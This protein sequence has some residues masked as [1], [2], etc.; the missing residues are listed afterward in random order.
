MTQ[1]QGTVNQDE[2]NDAPS[3]SSSGRSH[4]LAI[5]NVNDKLTKEYTANPN[6]GDTVK[7]NKVPNTVDVGVLLH[8]VKKGNKEGE[9]EAIHTRDQD[10]DYDHDPKYDGMNKPDGHSIRES[11]ERELQTTTSRERNIHA[12]RHR[13]VEKDGSKDGQVITAQ[14][15]HHAVAQRQGTALGQ[16]GNDNDTPL[17][18]SSGSRR[19][20][21]NNVND[22]L[23]KKYGAN[24]YGDDT[25]VKPNKEPN[26]VDVGVLLHQVEEGNDNEEE[27]NHYG[28]GHEPEYEGM[29]KHDNNGHSIHESERHLE[30][31]G[32]V[33]P[34]ED[35]VVCV[36][37]MAEVNGLPV[38]CAVACGNTIQYVTKSYGDFSYT[39]SVATGGQCCVGQDACKNFTGSVCKDNISCSGFEVC[40]N[41]N[42]TSVLRGCSDRTACKS[43]GR[44]G[45]IGT[46]RDS[47]TDVDS[48]FGAGENG[49]IGDI[50][51]SCQ[52]ES[53][54]ERAANYG[55][56]GDIT[57]SCQGDFSCQYAAACYNSP[58]LK[59]CDDAENPYIKSITSSCNSDN[60]CQKLAAGNNNYFPGGFVN[61]IYS[62][63]NADKAC[64]K[65]AYGD[66]DSF[67]IETGFY[68]CCNS[69]EGC[70]DATEATLPGMDTCDK[71][72][73]E[74]SC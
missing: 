21:I 48:C 51:S 31:V 60:S 45:S 32:N 52:G 40:Y 11:S 20:A 68:N 41:A 12:P 46:V 72:P 66:G 71:A 10:H 64:Y 61:G 36:N 25:A 34:N 43:A 3:S 39:F 30:V 9:G 13:Q 55:S 37:G 42:I 1:L 69:F 56:I 49:S 63:C 6:D 47:C 35:K 7:P 27:N 62:S 18:S 74:V 29:N 58:F 44:N 5:N 67:N 2:G 4:R 73:S 65:A 54:C 53:S 38:S 33:C 59:E 22:R 15:D 23:T 24:T 26:T 70:K 16:T 57:S 50:T 8:Q 19:L 28:H 14:D 17:S